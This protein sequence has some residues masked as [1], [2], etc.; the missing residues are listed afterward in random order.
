M[1]VRL[2]LG[3]ATRVLCSE[4][5]QRDSLWTTAAHAQLA[6]VGK[7]LA[8][9]ESEA[10][11]RQWAIDGLL[12]GLWLPA[13]SLHAVLVAL[14]CPM[15]HTARQALTIFQQWL[16]AEFKTLSESCKDISDGTAICRAHGQA[17]QLYFYINKVQLTLEQP[18]LN[19]GIFNSISKC[20]VSSPGS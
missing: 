3:D 1:A 5:L 6:S 12:I 9:T 4:E 7:I 17:A 19:Y 11:E 15:S 14:H 16:I 2:L 13:G 8:K 20:F 18:P 10:E